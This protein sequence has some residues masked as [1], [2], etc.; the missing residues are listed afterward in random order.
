[1][2]QK[3]GNKPLKDKNADVAKAAELTA[4]EYK[5][6]ETQI[7]TL[8]E[9]YGYEPSGLKE[10]IQTMKLPEKV[11]HFAILERCKELFVGGRYVN[12]S[13]ER[14]KESVIAKLKEGFQLTDEEIRTAADYAYESLNLKGYGGHLGYL[15]MELDLAKY[16][17]LGKEK[18][19]A[20]AVR[21]L[22][23]RLENGDVYRGEDGISWENDPATLV[24]E[25][26]L[27]KA[28]VE[29]AVSDAIIS[30]FSDN[31]DDQSSI[32]IGANIVEWAEGQE[33]LLDM[34]IV[35]RIKALSELKKELDIFL[36]KLHDA[37]DKAR[38]KGLMRKSEEKQPSLDSSNA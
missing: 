12:P 8:I 29:S 30:C 3:T 15:E 18:E 26:G 9:F 17:N 20:T 10:L 4:A 24:K 28:E 2:T 23:Y 34:K 36:K 31:T 32:E 6:Y 35:N 33:L 13:S 5:Q 38:S 21:M 14:Y 19:H 22:T 37:I 27:A 1:M 25:N 7:N 16:Y 11:A